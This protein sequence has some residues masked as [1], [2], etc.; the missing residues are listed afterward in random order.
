M[1][2]DSDSDGFLFLSLLSS[3]PFGFICAIIAIVLMFYA[4]QNREECSQKT[5]PTGQTPH[6]L[7]HACLC[8][9]EA[10]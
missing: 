6:L 8:T 4:C 7:D 5:C 3:G 9:S 2:D 1:I 10:K